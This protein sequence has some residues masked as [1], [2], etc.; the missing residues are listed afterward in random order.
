MP[1]SQILARR[2]GVHWDSDAYI[3]TAYPIT[4]A[5]SARDTL[6]RDRQPQHV[7]PTMMA[8]KATAADDDAQH[9]PFWRRLK[10]TTDDKGKSTTAADSAPGNKDVVGPDATSATNANATAEVKTS[11]TG[12]VAGNVTGDTQTPEKT[13]PVA[14]QSSSQALPASSS[15]SNQ[16]VPVTDTG[17]S[18]AVDVAVPVTTLQTDTALPKNESNGSITTNATAVAQADLMDSGA[19]GITEATV[20]VSGLNSS[21]NSVAAIS[22]PSDSSVPVPKLDGDVNGCKYCVYIEI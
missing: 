9:R 8:L 17:K 14:S 7:A 5:S 16:T 1:N 4:E 22:V 19:K 10:R 12:K 11:E 20:A 3:A 21:S 18:G 15:V 6:A 13:A 2:F